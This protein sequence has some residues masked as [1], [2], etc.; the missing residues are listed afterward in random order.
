MNMSHIT[1][2]IMIASLVVAGC[3]EKKSA[4]K[5]AIVQNAVAET[6]LT[7]ITL[8]DAAVKR[9]GIVT[10]PAD[11]GKITATR[12]IG[13]ELQS[14]PGQNITMSAPSA[15]I[16]VPLGKQS[17]PVPGAELKRGETV[18][19]FIPVQVGSEASGSAD[20]VRVREAEYEVA[21]RR[22]ERTEKL[23]PQRGASMEELE[24][25]RADLARAEARLS[26]ARTQ[27]NFTRNDGSS[28]ASGA[29]TMGAPTTGILQSMLVSAGQ[30]VAAGQPLFNIQGQNPLW[31]R[32]QV[33]SGQLNDIDFGA[34]AQV[35]AL[36][37]GEDRVAQPTK[38][39]VAANPVTAAVDV[40]YQLDNAD[41]RFR[42]GERALL[43][44]PLKT[45]DNRLSVPHAAILRDI[46]G[47]T[48]VYENT[49]PRTYVRRR[50]MVAHIADGIA[51]LTG[52]LTAGQRVVTAGVA[53]LAGSEFGVGK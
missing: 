31:A 32:V 30:S 16:V 37:G 46:H 1:V 23:V 48:W 17:I 53:E 28:A 35:V 4:E 44:L 47:G 15:G 41:G 49:A 42:S 26:I 34:P 27:R 22:A 21:R 51:I 14:V 25:A 19:G 5:P 18:L 7:T 2:A 9:L 29:V 3:D 12:V 13:G 52:G 10:V 50:V 39:P 45:S 36:G 8:T 24:T 11:T 43:R 40:Y 20:D 38:G 6:D 33:F